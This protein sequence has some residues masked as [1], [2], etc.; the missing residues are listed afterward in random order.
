LKEKSAVEL[1]KKIEKIPFI[2][3][4]ANQSIEKILFLK[5]IA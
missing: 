2:I 1:F 4:K 5:I 3:E